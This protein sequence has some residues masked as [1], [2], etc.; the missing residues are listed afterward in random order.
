MIDVNT[1]PF[2]KSEERQKIQEQT[3]SDIYI[4][5]I[6]TELNK[7]TRNWYECNNCN[8]L[9]RSPK[10]DQAEQNILYE[11]YR[12]VSFRSETP[13]DYFNRISTYPNSKSENYS[14]M[15]WFIKNVDSE[16]LNK[17]ETLLDVGCG[18]GVLLHKIKEMMP[19]LKT[20]G[21]EPNE[22]YSKL[23]KN[24]SNAE[25]IQTDYFN[26]N[27]F[28]RK[29]DI[30]VSSDVL[31]HVDEP[32]SF[33]N[34]IYN[35]LEEN[36]IIYLEIPSPSCFKDLSAEHDMFNIAHHV[37]FT[38]EILEHYL[39][40]SGFKNIFIQDLKNISSIWKLRAIAYR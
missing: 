27:S 14:K 15:D 4:E 10:L 23:A 29:F 21:I 9:Y 2:C 35:S 33:L 26:E 1:C 17:S 11:K 7:I 13:D 18:G 30:I 6:D 25:D 16:L 24:K 37:F 3:F 19:Q 12:D 31:E 5:L 38:E 39:K 34:E 22:S 28:S 40:E 32:K 20:Y 8:F 36:G